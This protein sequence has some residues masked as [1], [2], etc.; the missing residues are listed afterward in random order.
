MEKET[1]GEPLRTAGK[2]PAAALARFTFRHVR[3]S[4]LKSALTVVAAL[5]FV[6]A[7][8]WMDWTIAHDKSEI[9]RMY[10]S[11]TVEGEIVPADMTTYYPDG[12]GGVIKPYTVDTVLKSGFVQSSY[13]E[14]STEAQKVF[15]AKSGAS[16]RKAGSSLD[17]PVLRSFHQPKLFFST[18]GKNLKVTYASGWDE[19]LFTKDWPLT[20][21][22]P[23]LLPEE[24]M[25]QLGLKPGD[26]VTILSYGRKKTITGNGIVAGQYQGELLNSWTS[27]PILLPTSAMGPLTEDSFCYLTAKF[28][29]KPSLNRRMP[30]F[31]K[32]MEA[33]VSTPSAGFAALNFVLWDDQ[34]RQVLEPLER[35]LSLMR[36]L[37]PVTIAVSAL[38]AAAVSVL[39]L[40]QRANEAAVMRALGATKTCTCAG[41]CG[42]QL[43]LCLLGV[44][45]GLAAFFLLR[46]GSGPLAGSVLG[47]AA[48]YFGGCLCGVLFSALSLVRRKPLDLLQVKE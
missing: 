19:S 22:V 48:A 6:L 45:L 35:N 23:V 34:L 37:F 47:C 15:P 9:D 21:D 7:M 39:L 14:E 25:L 40:L 10:R 36:V 17:E 43:F 1:C 16:G 2:F 46:R 8:G 12:G 32:A 44:L 29:L 42:E 27:D 26:R 31:R 33:A 41:I 5:C 13:L 3:R 4:G 20:A 24:M 38:I 30:E 18:T 11:I 28:T